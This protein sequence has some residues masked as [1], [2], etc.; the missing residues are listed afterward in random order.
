MQVLTIAEIQTGLWNEEVSVIE[1]GNLMGPSVGS[2]RPSADSQI[3]VRL[4]L[5]SRVLEKLMVVT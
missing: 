2:S 3:L 1:C 4:T 5:W